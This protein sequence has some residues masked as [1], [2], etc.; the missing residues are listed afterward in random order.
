MT[1]ISSE[2]Q[3]AKLLE[4]ILKRATILLNA[5]G[6]D[7]GLYNELEDVID[8]VACYQM[9][10]D[11]VGVRLV[12]GEGAMGAAMLSKKPIIIEDYSR[13]QYASEQYPKE[14]YHSVIAL[15]FMIGDRVIG[16]IAIMADDPKRI[17][18]KGDEYLLSLFA[19]HAAIAVENARLIS[20]S[21]RS[22]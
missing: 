15:P 13:W 10:K 12:R 14:T 18:S 22:C 20:R 2:L 5:K 7:L 16:A 1:D 21:A 4:L 3:L 8:I 6:G 11:L 19:Q 17:F 9:E